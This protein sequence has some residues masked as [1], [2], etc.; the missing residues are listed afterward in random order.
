MAGITF[1]S[2]LDFTSYQYSAY[3]N[4]N[5][6]PLVT[7]GFVDGSL[8][9]F[10]DADISALAAGGDTTSQAFT[11]TAY[12]DNFQVAYPFTGL[13]TWKALSSKSWSGSDNWTDG[14]GT[15]GAPGVAPRP[16]DTDTATFSVSGSQTQID[17][18]GENPN[19]KSLSF[20]TSSYTLSGGSLTMSGSTATVNVSSGTQTIE[21]VL[22]LASTTQMT[23][24]N[25]LDRLI[26]TGNIVGAGALLKNGAGTLI[27]SG[28]NSYTGGT[29]VL[30]GILAVTYS[31]ALPNNRGLTIGAGGTLIFD[32]SFHASTA[33]GLSYVASPMTQAV[34]EPSTL[35]L[36]G[37]T[38]IG[39]LAYA[40]R[41]RKPA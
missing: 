14:N 10:T 4:Y 13:A 1:L 38:T 27:L 35:A 3:L 17:L 36:L 34:P 23:V 8:I 11:G 40:W 28:T 33:Q 19:L 25:S 31:H 5:S 18:T 24:T 39:L 29:N 32:P 22:T 41:N 16:V 15:K 37:V 30:A 6:T 20:S 21:S 9:S 12:Y 26:I 2:P 7:E